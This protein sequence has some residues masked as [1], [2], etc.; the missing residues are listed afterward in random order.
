MPS[1]SRDVKVPG[2]SAAEIYD[3]VQGGIDRF[4]SKTPI[5]KFELGKDEKK[6]TV[7][8]KSSMF[9]GTLT[10]AEGTI[11]VEAKLSL[12]AAPFKSKL[13]EGIDKWVSKTFGA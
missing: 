7:S 13:D 5:G 11:R 3:K 1:Y 6:K 9:N 2:K 8:V 4:L 12:L 10:C